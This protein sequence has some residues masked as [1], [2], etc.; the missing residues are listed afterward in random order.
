MAQKPKAFNR[1]FVVKYTYD[2]LGNVKKVHTNSHEN[3]VTMD[4][5]YHHYEYDADKRLVRTYTSTDDINLRLRASYFYYLHGPLKRIELG[6]KLQGIDFVY[7]INGWLTQINHPGT[8]A[9]PDADPGGDGSAGE[10]SDFRKDVFGMLL[11]YYESEMGVFQGAYNPQGSDPNRFHKL[12]ALE[13]HGDQFL[14]AFTSVPAN[15]RKKDGKSEVLDTFKQIGEA[16]EG[17]SLRKAPAAGPEQPSERKNIKVGSTGDFQISP[18]DERIDPNSLVASVNNNVIYTDPMVFDGNGAQNHEFDQGTTDWTFYDWAT[19]TSAFSVVQDAGLSGT[20]AARVNIANTDNSGWKVQLR[21]TLNFNLEVGSTYEISFIARAESPRKI[22][23]AFTGAP[24]S[25]EYWS[26]GDVNLTTEAQVFGPFQYTCNNANVANETSFYFRFY[27]AYGVNS[28][29]WIDK[30]IIVD[31]TGG[32]GAAAGVNVTPLNGTIAVGQTMLMTKTI[33]PTDATNQNVAWSSSNTAV[34]TVNINGLVTAVS[35]GSATITA[36]TA[37]GGYTGSS[38]VTILP[39]GGNPV[40]NNEFDEG[41]SHWILFDWSGPN[42]SN[43]GNVFSIVQGAGLSGNNA[44]HVDIVN[45][46]NAGWTIGL[47]NDFDFELEQGRT[48]EISFMAKAES[49]RPIDVAIRGDN[50]GGTYWSQTVN[51]TTAPQTFGPFLYTC[52]DPDVSNE[53]LFKINFYLAKGVLSDVWL[54]KVSVKDVTGSPGAVV[55]VTVSPTSVTLSAGQ[56]KQLV[57]TVVPVD[58]T[59]QNVT[60][61]SDNPSV[62]TANSA[63]LVTGVS[64]GSANI[65]ATTEDGGFAASSAFTVL[66]AGSNTLKNHEFDNDVDDWRLVDWTGPNNS[67]GGNTFSVVQGAGLSGD[68]AAYIDIVNDNNSG[69][70]LQLQQD[71]DFELEQGHT[72]EISFTSKAESN[73]PLDAGLRGSSSNY[74]DTSVNLTTSSQTFGPFLYTCNDAGVLTDPGLFAIVFYLSEGMISDVWIDNVIVKDVT[75]APGAVIGV[76]VSPLEVT[77]AAGQ[78]KKL[79]HTVS[80]PDASNLN[81]TW[82][83]DNPTVATVNSSGIVT[84][85][86]PGSAN[87][88][89]TTEDGG[90]TA[91]SSFTVLPAGSN[92]LKNHEFD[93]D[94]NYW[95]FHD[96]TGPNNSNGGNT[97][98]VVQDAGLSGANAA[99]IDIVNNDNS[100]WTL[101]LQQQLDFELE[102]GHTYEVS[103]TSK[104]ESSRPLTVALRGSTGNYWN[105]DVNLTTASQTFGPFLFTCNDAGVLTDPGFAVVFYLSKGVISDVWID[106]VVVRDITVIPVTGVSVSSTTLAVSTGQTGQLTASIL[107]AYASNQNVTWSSSNTAVAIV[108]ATGLVTPV[109][110]GTATITVTT[111]DGSFTAQSEVTVSLGVEGLVADDVEFAALKDFYDNLGGPN[112]ANKTNWPTPGDWPAT[113]SSS[114]FDTWYGIA[115]TNGDVTGIVLYTNNLIGGIPESLADLL[116]L[117]NLDLRINQISGTLPSSF[118]SMTSLEEVRFYGNQ[119]QGTI[120]GD[121]G[122]LSNLKILDVSN[123]R[124]S[125]SIPESIGNLTN[126]TWLSLYKNDISGVIPETLY[127]L[128]NLANLYIYDVPITGQLSESI[129]NLS[130]LKEIWLYRT[131]LSGQLP[132]SLGNIN[133]LEALYLFSND[134]TGTIPEN[135]R[136]LINLKYLWLHWT[137]L[138]GELPEWISELTNLE[139]LSIG[140]NNMNGSIPASY[141]SLTNLAELYLERLDLSGPIPDA[142]QSLTN[143]TFVDLKHSGVEGTIPSWLMNMPATKTFILNDNNFTGLPDFSGRGDKAQLV[144]NV[145]NNQIPF[146]DIERYFTSGGSHPFKSF[147]YAPQRPSITAP[148]QLHVSMNSQLRIEAPSGGIHAVYLWERQNGYDW[149]NITALNE[150]SD[151]KVFIINN[152]DV[153]EAGPYRYRVSNSWIPQLVVQSPPIAVQIVDPEGPDHTG[154]L[155]NGIITSVSWR[156]EK[157][158]QSGDE[159]LDGTFIYT[160][161][162]K[163]QIKEAMFGKPGFGSTPGYTPQGNQFR[164]AGMNYDPNG[165]ILSLKRYDEQ[166]LRYNDF[167]YTYHNL[168]NKLESVAGYADGYVY[169]AIGQMVGSS[170]TGDFNLTND[171]FDY[172]AGF[173]GGAPGAALQSDG[174]IVITGDFSTYNGEFA[175]RIVRL[176]AD[177]GTDNSF[178]SGAGFNAGCQEVVVQPDGKILVSGF[179]TAYNGTTVGRIIRLNPDGSVDNT[180]NAGTG[181]SAGATTYLTLQPD[182]KIIV[183]GSFTSYNG[184]AANRIIRLNSNGSKDVTFITGSGFN[185][186]T[187]AAMLLPDGR[188]RICGSFTSYNGQAANRIIGLNPDGTLDTAFPIG[189]GFSNGI[190]ER[191]V[192]QPD[193]KIIACGS[194]TSYQGVSANGIIRLQ[195]WGMVDGSFVSGTGFND[196]VREVKLQPDGKIIVG[197]SFTSYN[198]TSANRTIR[199]NTDG[200][201]DNSFVYG[202]GFDSHVTSLLIRPDEKI[203]INGD[204]TSYNG[205]NANRII[206]LHED[207]SVADNGSEN[208]E[209]MSHKFVKY[210]VTGKVTDVYEGSEP[211]VSPGTEPP[212]GYTLKVSYLY[213]DRGF[214]LAKVNHETQRTTWYIRDASGNILSVYEQEG[215]VTE[216]APTNANPVVQTE[217][218]VYG[219]GK[220]GTYYPLQDGSMAYEITDHL[221]NVRALLRDNIS[222]YTATMEDNGTQDITNPAVEETMFFENVNETRVDDDRM[223]Y[224]WPVGTV[225]PSPDKAAYLYW[226]DGMAGI[227]AADK[228]IGPAIALKVNAG[229]KVEMETWVRYEEKISY[230]G[231]NL[232]ALASVLGGTFTSVQGFEGYTTTQTS[233]SLLGAFQTAGYPDGDDDTKPY[234]YLNYITYDDQMVY[235]DAGW[236]RVTD[237]AGFEPGSEGIPNNRSHERLSFSSPIEITQNGYIYIW[238]SNQSQATKVW[239]DDLKVTHTQTLVVQSTDYGAWGDVM[240]EQKSDESVYRFGYQ[241]QFAEKDE[242]TGWSHFELREY[243]AVIGRWMVP[244]PFGQYWS[245]YMAMG[246]NPVNL[247]DPDGGQT[248][249]KPGDLNEAGTHIWSLGENEE[250]GWLKMLDEITVKPS[251]WSFLDDLDLAFSGKLGIAFVGRGAYNMGQQDGTGKEIIVIDVETFN[252]LMGLHKEYNKIGGSKHNPSKRTFD[253]PDE[254]DRAENIKEAIDKF[255]EAIKAHNDTHHGLTKAQQAKSARDS[256][257]GSGFGPGPAHYII[258]DVLYDGKPADTTGVYFWG[259]GAK[260]FERKFN[261]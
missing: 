229:D 258:D 130:S 153:D 43:G 147:T 198:G 57:H 257:E 170:T 252:T 210:D 56:S 4:G 30:V 100:G 132:S 92:T 109:S 120:P 106:N 28:D 32:S 162:N 112:W 237:A 160:Y 116:G 91:S 190:V 175:G 1:T 89:V 65:T 17:S 177:G 136:N 225:V 247:I 244:D 231:L 164:L 152:A 193:N 206:L 214:R 157:A 10:H 39:S 222:T 11:D 211:M 219:S 178:Q 186:T 108:D 23:A 168:T 71:L 248:D 245:P 183:T 2:F 163:Y 260:K 259:T 98:S 42:N 196:F 131:G 159:D 66:P 188:I 67:N 36:T 165:N 68:N 18:F 155:Y 224:T 86:A 255:Y 124:F 52:N 254:L 209:P 44:A 97:F 220:I 133:S 16:I 230:D 81:V 64:P 75:G 50:L 41:N 27:L 195:N 84:G 151:P 46:N 194:F 107:P 103:F 221:G 199:L 169:N 184:S 79:T 125:G 156:T 12:P 212:V 144:V 148:K 140:D 25:T 129:G 51:L 53:T 167:A 138:S 102:Q 187:N 54:D 114:E 179:F 217:V 13:S 223:N 173:N 101:Q 29:V 87:I 235:Q 85:V 26:S 228:A 76:N 158:Y 226:V 34:A 5:F 113:A 33:L 96:W 122:A 47:R 238:V 192:L 37:D 200:T 182:G 250:Y 15:N 142:L 180:F 185:G 119:L 82:S 77:L 171:S 72:Y 146:E 134:F 105:A 126:L 70:T 6:E 104:A 261:K 161:D 62:A 246:N 83:T 141:S 69:W 8:D 181:F 234:A 78:V 45:T 139:G 48:Y 201:I 202:S 88:T 93:N 20:N 149:I 127:N 154:A 38:S 74:W 251:F 63:G 166:A 19:G 55:G 135:W 242:E 21:Q 40:R 61:S 95:I 137:Q 31:K 58:A 203:L 205:V 80:P 215:V 22:K 115:V 150:S 7:N 208:E 240:R 176:N 94:K 197:G 253:N 216:A 14:N 174:R 207:G 232:A 236:V 60:W 3:G 121:I 118:T 110:P 145:E 241:G 90:F 73:R 233:Q 35:A 123:N 172:G 243:D 213:D 111:A 189:T 143:L 239:F 24:S 9:D 227:E 191:L 249:P 117:K 49:N 59:N 128:T 218:P 204:F 99:Y 256:L